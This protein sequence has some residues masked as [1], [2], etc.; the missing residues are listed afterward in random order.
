MQNPAGGHHHRLFA[1]GG[2]R[3]SEQTHPHALEPG[4]S[5]P[6]SPSLS[7][8][9]SLLSLLSL[10]SLARYLHSSVPPDGRDDVTCMYAD[11]RGS[12]ASC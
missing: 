5:L 10:S 9:L 12:E 11:G 4:L 6:L 3:G 7:P 1:L 8:P 2:Y